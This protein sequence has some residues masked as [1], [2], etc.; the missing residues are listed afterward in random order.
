[1]MTSKDGKKYWDDID[2]VWKPIKEAKQ[3]K[4]SAIKTKQI[5]AKRT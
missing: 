1:M 2:Y 3:L 5:K 4:S